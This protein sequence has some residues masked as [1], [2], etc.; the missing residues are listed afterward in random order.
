MNLQE[1]LQKQ[2]LDCGQF[3]E[4]EVDSFDDSDDSWIL[5]Q[6]HTKEGVYGISIEFNRRGTVLKDIKV[7]HSPYVVSDDEIEIC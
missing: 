4:V 3:K 2:L 6:K 7:Y 5:A 1:K